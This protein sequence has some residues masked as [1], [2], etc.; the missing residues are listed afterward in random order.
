MNGDKSDNIPSLLKPKKALEAATD[1]IKFKNFMDIE[2]N[3]TNFSVN[4]Q[5]IEF[6]PVPEEEISLV[7][8]VKDFHKLY[9]AFEKMK[10]E[11]IIKP[12]SWEKYCRTFDC[13][14]Y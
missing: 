2:E 1:P 5:L 11:S 12:E 3:R 14:K 13:I 8:G 9:E 4:R 10:F 6:K 7:E